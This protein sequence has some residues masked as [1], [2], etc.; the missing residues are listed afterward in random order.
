MIPKESELVF[1]EMTGTHNSVQLQNI[2]YL[3][4]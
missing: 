1:S 4:N 2:E 3:H